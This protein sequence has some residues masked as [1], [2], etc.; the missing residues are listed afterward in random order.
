MVR[1]VAHGHD[2]IILTREKLWRRP[3][4]G[5]CDKLEGTRNWQLDKVRRCLSYISIISCTVL[6]SAAIIA[7]PMEGPIRI[8]SAFRIH[9][10]GTSTRKIFPWT[11][12]TGGGAPQ[13]LGPRQKPET[14]L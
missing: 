13:E 2:V 11:P 12:S 1:K 10:F 6:A 7:K 8:T 3:C 4:S 14:V 9:W 5:P